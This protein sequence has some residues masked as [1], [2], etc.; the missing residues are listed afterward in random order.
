[1][2]GYNVLFLTSAQSVQVVTDLDFCQFVYW[3]FFQGHNKAVSLQ[4]QLRMILVNINS[5]ANTVLSHL[6]QHVL[7]PRSQGH[8]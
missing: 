6:L 2:K 5:G 7:Q 8:A 4:S 3:H 1:M